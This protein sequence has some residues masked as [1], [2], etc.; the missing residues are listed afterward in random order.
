L[1]AG[2]IR[3][4]GLKLRLPNQS[5][6]ILRLLL[7]R[8]GAVVTHEELCDP[9]WPKGSPIDTKHALNAAIHKL[10]QVLGDS[11]KRPRYIET[12]PRRGYR[13]IARIRPPVD[14]PPPRQ[15]AKQIRSVAVLPL[16]NASGDPKQEYFADGMTEALINDLAKISALR[17]IARASAMRYKGTHKSLPEIA[18]ELDVDGVVEGSVSRVGKRVRIIVQ[19][20]H[21]GSNTCLWAQSYVRDFRDIFALQAKVA[22]AIATEIRIKVTSRERARL[23]RRHRRVPAAHEAYLMGRHYWNKRTPEGL[24]N[25]LKFFE[26]AIEKDPGYALA[27]AGLADTYTGFASFFHDIASPLEVMPKARAAAQKALQVDHSLAEA[28]ATLA[29]INA[30]HNYDWKTAERGYQKALSLNPGYAMAIHWHAMLLAYQGKLRQAQAE[31]ERARGTD[32]LSLPININVA[33]VFY[34]QRDYDRAI[35]QAGRTLE[36]DPT[37]SNAHF[38]LSFA[39][40]QKAMLAEALA[41]AEKA[42]T[43]SGSNAASLGCIGGCYAAQGRTNEA[44]KIIGDLQKLSKRQYV[45]PFIIGWLYVNLRDKEA[46]LAYLER[47]YAERSTYL[48]LIKIEPSLDFLRSDPRFQDLQRRIGLHP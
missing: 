24:R 27:Y 19:L 42:A 39:L 12:L 17:V 9:L 13:F 48:S 2:Q 8:P 7:K 36:L 29:F 1:E 31:I 5:F 22:Q 38:V 14:I 46:A 30:V 23:A 6:E 32:P 26:Q 45:S 15:L 40:Q 35:E 37:F 20:V 18:R 11:A 33:A 21:A 43:L 10:R 16:K 4:S 44:R 34:F 25:S 47:A 3:K 28:H 41:E